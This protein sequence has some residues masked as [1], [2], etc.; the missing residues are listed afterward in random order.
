MKSQKIA[1]ITGANRGI[2]LETA[3][4]LG[5]EGVTVIVA[6]RQLK[7]ATA[8]AAQLNTEGIDAH[9]LQLDVT[10]AADRSAAAAYITDKF[11]K[12]DILVNNAGIGPKEESL[13]EQKTVETDAKEFSDVFETNFFSVVYLTK[14][15]LPLLKKSAAGRIVNLS[16]ILGSLTLHAQQD[17]PIG[18]FR[19]LSYNASK[20]ALNMFT[21]HLAAELAGTNIK[22]NSA[23]PGWVKTELGGVEQAPMEITDGAKTSVSLSLLGEDGSNGRFVHLADELP[24]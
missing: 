23:H 19:R 12:L 16:S 11:G 2:G 10:K 15:L 17:S 22:V 5:K 9:G 7:T 20:A 6:A 18:A 14:E 1:L 3:R 4:Q 24:W 13:S 8:A 21:I